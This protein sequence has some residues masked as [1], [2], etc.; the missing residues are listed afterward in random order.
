MAR[1]FIIGAVA[2]L[3][4]AVIWFFVSKRQPSKQEVSPSPIVVT[5]TETAQIVIRGAG[6]HGDGHDDD[7]NWAFRVDRV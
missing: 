5:P 6:S 3:V 1:Q 2:V 4:I 7:Y